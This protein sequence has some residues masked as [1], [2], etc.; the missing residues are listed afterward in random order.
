MIRYSCILLPI[1]RFILAGLMLLCWL[2]SAE[3]SNPDSLVDNKPMTQRYMFSHSARMYDD[4]RLLLGGGVSFSDQ[5]SIGICYA[6]FSLGGV[7]YAEIGCWNYPIAGDP[8]MVRS[9]VKARLLNTTIVD[10]AL[11]FNYYNGADSR[12]SSF[13]LL[14]SLSWSSVTVTV[15]IGIIPGS[16][17]NGISQ[18]TGLICL[19]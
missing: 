17:I 16:T 6:G 1:G 5:L 13:S 18:N 12:F 4:D 2:T 3:A 11:G 9:V 15:G 10:L 8:S 14:S 19:Q 7:F